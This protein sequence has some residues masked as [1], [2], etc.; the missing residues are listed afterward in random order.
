MRHTKLILGLLIYVNLNLKA[1]IDTVDTNIIAQY[2]YEFNLE[3]EM[4][5]GQGADTLLTAINDAQYVMLGNHHRS[6][7]EALALA[8]ARQLN[9]YGC[10]HIA[11]E[12]GVASNQV[13]I[14]HLHSEEEAS[15]QLKK[16]NREFGHTKNGIFY[17]PIPDL[18]SKASAQT[19]DYISKQNWMLHGIGYDSWKS[20]KMIISHLYE[21]L[22]QEEQML[23]QKLYEEV[24]FLLDILYEKVESQN[25]IDILNFSDEL[26]SSLSIQKL[27]NTFNKYEK[28]EPNIESLK[29]SIDYWQM[30]GQQKFYKKNKLNAQRNKILL[31]QILNHSDFNW[32]EDKLFIRM[33]RQ[34]LTKGL[35]SNGF[36]GIGNTLNELAELQGKKAVNI[37][38]IQKFHSKD[39]KINEGPIP[40]D[41][42]T[43]LFKDF[44]P[45]GKR[46]RYVLIDLTKFNKSFFWRGYHV[47]QSIA[48]IYKRYD[49]LIISKLDRDTDNNN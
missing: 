35:T 13:L 8:I 26:K 40:N 18:K 36:Y 4:L 32:K 27:F 34:H 11:M 22:P 14:E 43:S 17:A 19:I 46:D 48:D 38:V 42:Y 1:Q 30:Y 12:I 29:F 21:S 3:G 7:Q 9:I 37:A 10:H 20:Y 25:N 31:N 44:I 2:A 47:P 23:N 39:N 28:L 49:Y 41:Y 45:L 16:L 33:W 24:K 6:Y 15:V 5:S